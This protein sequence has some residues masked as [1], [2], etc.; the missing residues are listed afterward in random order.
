MNCGPDSPQAFSRCYISQP[1][2]LKLIVSR[3]LSN[4]WIISSWIKLCVALGLHL[5]S[6]PGISSSSKNLGVLLS[7][8]CATWWCSLKSMNE[9]IS[10]AVYAE[11]E[12]PQADPP[13]KSPL[14]SPHHPPPLSPPPLPGC[15]VSFLFFFFTVKHLCTAAHHIHRCCP[16]APPALQAFSSCRFAHNDLQLVGCNGSDE[17]MWA[18]HCIMMQK[19]I[20]GGF[21]V[22][23]FTGSILH[24]CKRKKKI[25][26]W[27]WRIQQNTN[28]SDVS[29][30][31]CW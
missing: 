10:R 26:A 16:F 1:G 13:S 5:S 7:L 17:A 23:L 12:P 21:S 28:V 22:W 20:A 29:S 24:G 31:C 18:V 8:L 6:Q 11:K 14:S 4:H 25:F 27:R 2:I 19:W 3:F 30:R 9:A 15:L